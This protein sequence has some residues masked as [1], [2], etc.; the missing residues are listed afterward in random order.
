[1]KEQKVS[2]LYWGL[3]LA[4]FGG[5]MLARNLGYIDFEISWHTHWPIALIV[6][7]GALIIRTFTTRKKD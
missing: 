2:D 5:F 1:M 6:V 7:G 3:L 4:A